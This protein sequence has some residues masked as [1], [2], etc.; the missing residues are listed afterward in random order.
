[1]I[2]AL[3][4]IS[5]SEIGGIFTEACLLPQLVGEMLSLTCMRGAG[6]PS[7]FVAASCVV[8]C[9]SLWSS[10]VPSQLSEENANGLNHL[11][12]YHESVSPCRYSECHLLSQLIQKLV[13]ICWTADVVHCPVFHKSSSW[14]RDCSVIECRPTPCGCV[15]ELHGGKK[16]NHRKSC[17]SGWTLIWEISAWPRRK[18]DQWERMTGIFLVAA[19]QRWSWFT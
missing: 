17:F 6:F 4:A 5:Q 15:Y 8:G 12:F 10:H 13:S 3:K 19:S 9:I 7:S 2:S 11:S 16:G 14:R 18:T 1:M